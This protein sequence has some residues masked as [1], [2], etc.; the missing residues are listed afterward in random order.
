MWIFYL[1]DNGNIYFVIV[2]MIIVIL[3]KKEYV[4]KKRR[5][6]L[7]KVTSDTNLGDPT[8]ILNKKML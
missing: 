7:K 4:G 1:H 6:L 8:V 3:K 5:N 2:I